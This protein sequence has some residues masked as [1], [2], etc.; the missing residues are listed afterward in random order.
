MGSRCVSVTLR[1][2]KQV[3]ISIGSFCLDDCNF[4]LYSSWICWL[5]GFLDGKLESEIEEARFPRKRPLTALMTAL[6]RE[7]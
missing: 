3:P 1:I 7:T 2:C 5:R 4:E 6:R